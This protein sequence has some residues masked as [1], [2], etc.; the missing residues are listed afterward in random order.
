[1]SD[2]WLGVAGLLA[3]WALYL[4][5]EGGGHDWLEGVF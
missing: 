1:M 3:V 5:F 4:I 2:L